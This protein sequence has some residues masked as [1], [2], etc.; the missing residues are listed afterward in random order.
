MFKLKRKFTSLFLVRLLILQ[1]IL[2]TYFRPVQGFKLDRVILATDNNPMYL[3]FWPVAAKVWQQVTGLRPTLALVADSSVTVDETLGDVIR[4][5]PIPGISTALQAQLIRLLLPAFFPDDG[6]LL[7]DIDMIPLQKNYF[8]NHVIN[9]SDDCFV[10]YRNRAYNDQDSH[11]PMCYNAA[12]GRVFADIFGVPVLNTV[13][14]LD[15]FSLD[16]LNNLKLD[17]FNKLKAS[18]RAIIVQ[19]AS[20]DHGWNTDEICLTQAIKKW[21]NYQ[22]RV[23]KLNH[24][25]GPRVDRGRWK[26]DINFLKAGGYLD[27]HLLRPYAQYKSEIDHLIKL[28]K[29]K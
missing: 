27:S 6:C 29:I 17:N 13:G 8:I 16:E 1:L 21:D 28:L 24:I 23:I 2:I 5:E 11:Y 3:E 10:V 4:F 25:T 18:I 15:G 7:S 20:L 19:W 22:T 9:V 12:K 26:Y 14:N